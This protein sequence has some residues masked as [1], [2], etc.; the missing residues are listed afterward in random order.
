MPEAAILDSHQHFWRYNAAEYPWLGDSM[1]SLQRDFLPADFALDAAPAG[2]SGSIAV[3]A[4][5]SIA[6]T[7]WLLALARAN[8][9][10]R[11][12]VGWAPLAEPSAGAAVERLAGDPLLK[13]L[14]HVLHDEPDPAFMLRPAFL[15]GL[16]M[17]RRHALAFDLLIF[18]KHLPHAIELARRFP[19]QVFVLD[20]LAKPVIRA[21]L[22]SPWR[23]S[24]AQ[25]ARHPNV[26]CKLSGMVTEA[27]WR[28][29]T[30]ADLMPYFDVAL[31]AF[32]PSRLMFGS[33]WPVLLAASSY[34]AWLDFLRTAIAP[35]TPHE[36]S[37]ILATTAATAY[38]LAP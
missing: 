25:L 6:E 15:E 2:V 16:A 5:Q 26:Y 30:P 38:R 22:L 29:W 3:Q 8:P 20:H 24:I 23:E 9:S 10:I 33:D 37:Q 4:R 1:R 7:E 12:V 32:G 17:L 14:R 28:R 13:G 34:P 19:S 27:L 36:Q 11:G 35:L 31:H 21:G 18:P